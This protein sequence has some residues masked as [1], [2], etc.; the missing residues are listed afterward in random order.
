MRTLLTVV[1]AFFVASVNAHFQLQFPPPRGPFV[2][3]SEPTFCD[4]YTNSTNNRTLFPLSGGFFSMNS[5]HPQW[6][7]TVLLATDAANT[8]SD[9]KEIKPFFQQ[10]GEGIYCFPLLFNSPNATN[11]TNGEN[12]TIQILFDG[13]DGELFQCADLTLS[14]DVTLST[15]DDKCGNATGTNGTVPTGGS[16]NST[17]SSTSTSASP[18]KSS[19][20]A[21]RS[22]EFSLLTVALGL[23]SLAAGMS[24]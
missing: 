18:T 2:M 23:A 12:V 9:F 6:T 1:S 13:G 20:S 24:F 16:A 4:G 17:A 8:F 15:T 7:A 14:N 11:L 5:E 21:E 22:A 19:S 3:N 10:S